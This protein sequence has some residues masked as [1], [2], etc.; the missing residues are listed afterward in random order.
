MIPVILIHSG[1]NDYLNFTISQA[2]EY[3][4]VILLGTSKI[5]P[6]KC[7]NIP[8]ADYGSGFSAFEKNYVHLN[9]TPRDYEIFCYKRWFILRDFMRSMGLRVVFYI[10]S[11]VLLFADVN[12]EEKKFKQFDLTLLHRTAAISSFITY[13]GIDNFC[14]FLERI[15]SDHSSYEFKKLASHFSVRQSCGLSGGVCDMTL[16]GMLVIQVTL[17]LQRLPIHQHFRVL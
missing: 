15:Y 7:E 17:H 2:S 6:E 8:L 9:T 10:D 1:Y 4:D 16:F 5:L 12:K 14:N 13:R 3:N 11:D